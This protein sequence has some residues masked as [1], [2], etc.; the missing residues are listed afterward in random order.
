MKN[1]PI[2]LLKGLLQ[3]DLVFNE[4]G[5]FREFNNTVVSDNR[6]QKLL[7]KLRIPILHQEYSVQNGGN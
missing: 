2:S 7:Q 6:F 4:V 3:R 5:L 1:Q